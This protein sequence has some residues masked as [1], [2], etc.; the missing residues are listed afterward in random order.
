MAMILILADDAELTGEKLQALREMFETSKKPTEVVE[1]KMR[2]MRRSL[3]E[4]RR[5]GASIN[6]IRDLSG[7]RITVTV[8]FTPEDLAKARKTFCEAY[9]IEPNVFAMIPDG[10]SC[11]VGDAAKYGDLFDPC[12]THDTVKNH[13][14][15]GR[16]LGMSVVTDGFLDP[17]DR[18]LKDCYLTYFNPNGE[19]NEQD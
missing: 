1:N 13:G 3:E 8:P 17:K 2:D 6:Q 16:L 4:V 10:W 9:K 7:D 15:L 14:Y 12:S 19:N 5:N 11:I 18:F